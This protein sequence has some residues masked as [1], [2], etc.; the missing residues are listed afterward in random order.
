VNKFTILVTKFLSLSHSYIKS[1]FISLLNSNKIDQ[2]ITSLGLG[3]LTLLIPLAMA[4]LNDIYQKRRDE[5]YAFSMLDLQV[6]LNRVFKIKKLVFIVSLIF[7]PM[8]FWEVTKN[9]LTF[10]FIELS[11]SCIGIFFIG[12]TIFEVVNWIKGSVIEYRLDYLKSLKPSENMIISWNSLW[13]ATE[14][15][16]EDP[17]I[18]FQFFK[19]FFSKIKKLVN[20][21]KKEEFAYIFTN[22]LFN[23]NLN[24]KN[25]LSSFIASDDVTL[26]VFEMHLDAYKMHCKMYSKSSNDRESLTDAAISVLNGTIISFEEKVIIGSLSTRPELWYKKPSLSVFLKDFENYIGKI[27]NDNTLS[28]EQKDDYPKIL[29]NIVFEELLI[30]I[31]DNNNAEQVL[32]VVPEKWKV[33]IPNLKDKD[34]F[35][36]LILF[37][38]FTDWIKRLVGQKNDRVNLWEVLS[39]LFPGCDTNLLIKAYKFAFAPIT[40]GKRILECVSEYE[41]NPKTVAKNEPA[42]EE[43]STFLLIKLLAEKYKSLEKLMN[44]DYLHRCLEEV[45][46]RSYLTNDNLNNELNFYRYFCDRMI[47]YLEK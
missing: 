1:F 30:Y 21:I 25:R 36:P 16:F 31:E 35:F 43:I 6:I 45:K 34:A 19:I 32:K 5:E 8:F 38:S 20:K 37:K 10:R 44:K 13:A 22:V 4:I 41:W 47:E 27:K 46:N 28:S 40:E 24:L 7:I 14:D 17:D 2:I 29:S 39:I 3:L 23:F 18:E 11:L 42:E 15:N 26:K 33:T 12:K 9:N